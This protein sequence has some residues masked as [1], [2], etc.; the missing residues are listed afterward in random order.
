MSSELNRG[1]AGK[2]ATLTN[3]I[4]VCGKFQLH[5]SDARTMIE[6]LI[7]I[8]KHN[9]VSVCEESALQTIERE[10]L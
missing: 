6:Q 2:A 10:R 3:V 7:A 4:S 9:W 8:V 5:A 1:V